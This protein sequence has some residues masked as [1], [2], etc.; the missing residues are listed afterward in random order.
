ME[1]QKIV[2]EIVAKHSDVLYL[3]DTSG[4]HKLCSRANGHRIVVQKGAKGL[5]RID[6]TLPVKG[7]DGT[8]PLNATNGKITCHIKPD[9]LDKF[10]GALI[11]PSIEK[12]DSKPVKMGQ[13]RPMRAKAPQSEA[14]APATTTEKAELQKRLD[15]I[16]A[17]AKAARA[18]RL[19]EEQ[20][21]KADSDETEE[22]T[23]VTLTPPD[24]NTDLG[25]QA[26]EAE[27]GVDLSVDA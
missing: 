25:V 9:S 27:T 7:Q 1:T 22:D 20:G 13:P 26:F 17:A 10:I 23:G 21:D 14:I 5:K 3:E 18:R 24:V 4:W 6:T 12:L 8:E 11:D 19:V 2:E 15:D 16:R